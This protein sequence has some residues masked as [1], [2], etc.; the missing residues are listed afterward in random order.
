MLGNIS[1]RADEDIYQLQVP[2]KE[3]S[4]IVIDWIRIGKTSL[5]PQLRLYDKNFNFL[6]N[7][8]LLGRRNRLK[9]RYTLQKDLSRQLY[10]RVSDAV[11]FFQ[12]ETGGYKSYQYL[13]KFDWKN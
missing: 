9:F 5:S 6:N 1:S 12:G 8:S 7:Y 11:G 10:I 3:S 4:T 2:D 13:L